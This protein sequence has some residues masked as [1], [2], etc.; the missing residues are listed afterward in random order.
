MTLDALYS[1]LCEAFVGKEMEGKEFLFL[2][3]S[4]LI[5]REVSLFM[6]FPPL[7]RWQL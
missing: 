3:C 2:S 6:L 7:C 4:R 5:L 1:R